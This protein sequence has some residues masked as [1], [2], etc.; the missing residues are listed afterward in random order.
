MRKSIQ[1]IKIVALAILLLISICP[2]GNLF[3]LPADNLTP[4]LYYDFNDESATDQMGDYSGTIID[5]LRFVDG[6]PEFGKAVE[7]TGKGYIELPDNFKLSN[8]DFTLSFLVK[9]TETK[10]DTVLFANKDGESGA[11]DGFAI[12]NYNGVFANAGHNG[13]RYDTSSYSRDETVLNGD[14]H[15]VVV[16][17]DRDRSL[18]LYVDGRLS[19]ENQDFSEL[20][21]VSLDTDGNY[22]LG[23]GN[24]GA[25][26]Q[27][28]MYDEFKVYNGALS[29]EE[30]QT[31]YLE[32]AGDIM[33]DL[34]EQL[35]VIVAKDI[36]VSSGA[37]NETKTNAVIAFVK[38]NL[39]IS[40]GIEV[41]VELVNGDTYL[42][43]LSKAG[44]TASKEITFNF[45]EK[46]VLTVATYNIYGWG[47]PN[48]QSINA[49][50]EEIDADIVG[51]Q[52]ANHRPNGGG[53]VEQLSAIG[54]YPYYAFK[55]GYGTDTIWGGS[56]IVSKY[57]L[58]NKGGANYEF[59]DS[60]NRCYVRATIEIDG[61]EVALYNTHIVWLTDP[62]QYAEYKEA[63]INQL[64]EAVNNDPTP[65]KIITGDF[66]SD[67]SKEELDQLLLN[68]NGANGWNNV[69][70][71]TGELDS[72]MAIGC[73]DHIFTTTNIEFLNINTLEGAPSD[74]DILYADLKLKDDTSLPTQLL[75]NTLK[76]AQTYIADAD[77]YESAGI[78]KLKDIVNKVNNEP[79][80]QENRYPNV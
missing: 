40:L 41:D 44:V 28:A 14:W 21:G 60:T 19:N 30:I 56:A 13:K 58:L 70:F 53:Q 20:A 1:K 6:R 32:Y 64:I 43:S 26:F 54:S 11:A 16:T 76:D 62:E 80:T 39:N 59:N 79:V 73:I 74:H 52:E 17:A 65:Y 35:D 18:A 77:K 46:D 51:L 24:T 7:I 4:I 22:V 29:F 61:K 25:Y 57:P 36:K 69:W 68:F 12:M 27:G 48:L 47:Y 37:D 45:V 66:N 15:H 38:N 23:A 71:E 8:Q 67:Q 10:N 42:V 50:L 2:I 49:K 63:E 75:D 9:S 31:L 72:S 55:E 78:N 5:E 33:A 3:A 34:Q